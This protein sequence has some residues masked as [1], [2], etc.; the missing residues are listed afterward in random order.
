MAKNEPY[1][2]SVKYIVNGKETT[3]EEANKHVKKLLE[4]IEFKA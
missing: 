3:L 1:I 4:K 2:K